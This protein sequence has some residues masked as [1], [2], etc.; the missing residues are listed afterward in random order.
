[1]RHALVLILLFSLSGCVS[2]RIVMLPSK[3]GHQSVVVVRNANGE[4]LLDQPYEQGVQ[5]SGYHRVKRSAET[6]VR[7]RYAPALSAQPQR[8][9]RFMMFFETASDTPLADSMLSIEQVSMKSLAAP[10]PRS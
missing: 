3:D 6:D 10:R 7:Q 1:M 8:E 2:E 5:R 9:R 4:V